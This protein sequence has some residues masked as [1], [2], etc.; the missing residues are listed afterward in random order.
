[1]IGQA[2]KLL[3]VVLYHRPILSSDKEQRFLVRYRLKWQYLAFRFEQPRDNSWVVG[4]PEV[5]RLLPHCPSSRL[6]ASASTHFACSMRFLRKTALR[7]RRAIHGDGKAGIVTAALR[8]PVTGSILRYA[9]VALAR[10]IK[11]AL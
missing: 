2:D 3:V 1:V 10:R 5:I 8:R 6:N 4:K 7:N 11:G 9:I